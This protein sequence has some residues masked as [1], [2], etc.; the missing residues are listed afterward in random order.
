MTWLILILGTWRITH[1]ISQEDG[2]WDIFERLRV[3]LGVHYDENSIPY[4]ANT[5]AKGILCMWCFS[6][7]TGIIVYLFHNAYPEGTIAVLSPFALS[8]AVIF[9]ELGVSKGQT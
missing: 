1:M 3:W 6:V 9:V 8:A 4:G 5:I 7:W 2:P